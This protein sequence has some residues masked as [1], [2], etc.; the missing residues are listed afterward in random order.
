MR[1]LIMS[2]LIWIYAVWKSLFTN[3]CGSERV[4][5]PVFFFFLLTAPNRFLRC[6]LRLL[7]LR[8]VSCQCLG[9]I[10][11]SFDHSGRLCFVILAL[12]GYLN[13][14]RNVR[15][16]IFWRVPNED[17]KQPAHPHRL[18]KALWRNRV[19]FAIRNEPSDD[20]DQTAQM[21]RLIW[22]YTGL[23]CPMVCSYIF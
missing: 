17:S 11:S 22:L 19:C 13:L 3:A 21:R 8:V 15:K 4:T 14:D 9:I 20:S 16:R 10:S 7:Q 23:A 5:V 1:R 6:V 18:I 2:R 12:P